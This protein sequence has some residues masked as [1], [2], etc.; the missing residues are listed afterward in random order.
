[1][2]FG[3][4]VLHRPFSFLAQNMCSTKGKMRSRSISGQQNHVSLTILNNFI[5]LLRFGN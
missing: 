1:M 3:A 5:S 2:P 4:F